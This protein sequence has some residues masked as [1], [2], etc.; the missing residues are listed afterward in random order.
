MVLIQSKKFTDSPL[1]P[2]A[3]NGISDFLTRNNTQAQTGIVCIAEPEN[4]ITTNVFVVLSV[5]FLE[6][7]SAGEVPGSRQLKPNRHGPAS[8][9][10]FL[11]AVAGGHV[12][13]P[14]IPPGASGP[15]DD[16]A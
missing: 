5:T 2:I 3:G 12:G 13:H 4:H 7:A 10:G 15:F 9:A 14:I 16:D 11:R 6:I 1:G 8:A